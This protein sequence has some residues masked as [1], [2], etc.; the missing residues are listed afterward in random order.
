MAT[1]SFK[2]QADYEKVVKLKEEIAKLETQ[3]KSFGRNTPVN[4]IHAVE[5]K[6]S[7]SKSQFNALATEAAKAGAVMNNDFKN[8]IAESTA[9]VDDL[10]MKII[11]Q[12]STIRT[13]EADVRRLSEAYKEMSKKGSSSNT[14]AAKAELD[15]AKKSLAEE[16]EALFALNQ[17]KSKASLATKKL[18]AEYSAFK[19]EAKQAKDATE[20]FKETAKEASSV[21][22][23]L[24]NT[25][26]GAAASMGALFTIQKAKEFAVEIASVRGQFQQLEMSFETMLQ[27]KSKADALMAQVVDTAAKTPFDLQGVASGAKQL[28]AYGVASEKVNETLIRLGDIASG[29]NIPLGDLVYLYG[30]TMAQGR[31]FTMD[32]RQFQGRGIPM[33]EELA[34]VMGV[35]KQK[36]SELVTAGKVGF[37]EMEQAIKNMTSEGGRF[38]N[39]MEKQSK[40]ITGQYSNLK[41]SISQMFN[42][43]GKSSEGAISGAI[44]L[45]SNLVENYKEVGEAIGKVVLIV[46]SYKAA[47]MTLNAV[48]NAANGVEKQMIEAL[49]A[50]T[51]KK[52]EVDAKE[53]AI[54][55]QKVAANET[56]IESLRRKLALKVEEYQ[57]NLLTAQNEEASAKEKVDKV[58]ELLGASEEK[59]KALREEAIAANLSGDAE[60]FATIQ[61]NLLTAANERDALASELDAAAKAHLAATTN[62]ETAASALN[63]LQTN[64]ETSAINQQ[65]TA[66]LLL[67]AAKQ[68][69]MAIGRGIGSVLANPYVLAAAAVA[70]L[71]ASVIGLI[72]ALNVEDEAQ[73]NVTEA[74][75]KHNEALDENK[76]KGE[77]LISVIK[78][79][80]KTN[81]EKARAIT[82][83]RA[84]YPKLFQDM[85][86][87][88]IL[89]MKQADANRKLAEETERLK[90][91]ELRLSLQRKREALAKQEGTQTVYGANGATYTVDTSN[92]VQARRLREEIRLLE[93]ELSNYEELKKK[94]EFNALPKEAKIVSL[95]EQIASLDAENKELDRQLQELAAKKWTIEELG[96]LDFDW[97][98]DSSAEAILAK[99]E[100][101]RKK[102][103]E[104]TK[105]RK[106]LE[107]EEPSPE[108]TA[109]Q[110]QARYNRKKARD[111]ANDDMIKAERD[112]GYKLTEAK[113]KAMDD[114]LVKELAQLEFNKKKEE[115]AREQ[116]QKDLLKQMQDNERQKWLA[117]DPDRKEYDFVPT[118][119]EN[120]PE[121]LAFV[122]QYKK[123]GEDA[124][125]AYNKAVEDTQT[126]WAFANRQMAIDAM[127]E[128]E[129]KERAQR[130]LDNEKE[131]FQLE[132]K[133]EA[134]L[135]AAEAAHIYA[136]EA[137]KAADPNYQIQ[138]FDKE[139]TSADY[140]A[141]VDNT[142]KKQY[143]ILADEYMSYIDKKSAIDASYEADKAE[144]EE[145]YLKTGDEKYK[146]SL[147]ERTKAY[148]KAQNSLEGE[149][150]TA[151]YRLIFGDPSKMTSATIEKALEAAR[152]KMAEL[153]KEAD[154]ETFQALSEA[155]DRLEDARDNNPFEGWGTSIM[156]V[157]R[158]LH[159]IRNLKKDIERYKASGDTK[160]QEAAE[161]QL[162]KSKK[163]LNKALIGTGVATFGDTLTKA[164]ASMKEVAEASGDIELMQQAKALE[165][166]GGFISSVASGFASG[167]PM[168]ALVGGATAL[169]DMLISSITETKV[170][171]AQAKKAFGDYLDE[172]A[173]KARTINEEDY[174][175]IFG[176][177]T[178]DK[179]HDATDAAGKAWE[180]YQAALNKE[181]SNWWHLKDWQHLAKN[182]S[183]M[184]VFEGKSQTNRN[185]KKSKTLAERFPEL[186]NSDDTIKR[187]EAKMILDSYSQYASEEWYKYLQYAYDALVDYEDN[188]KIVDNYLTSLFS[189]VGSEITDAIM[190]GNDALEVLEQ[191]AGEIFKS[192]A[193]EMIMSTLIPQDFIGKYKEM[194]RKTMAT[195]GAED[196]AMVLRDFADELGANIEEASAQWEEL[197]RI[198]EEKGI[199]MFGAEDTTQQASTKGYQTLSE[200]TGNELVGRALAQYESNLRME[201][202]MGEMQKTM[203]MMS[204]DYITVK[205]I[206]EES[207]ALIASSYLEL[208]QIR[209]NTGAIIKPIKN[210]SD[211]IDRWDNK[212]MGL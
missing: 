26:K 50:T 152:K 109:K 32:L 205:N 203:E 127:S 53:L 126:K 114:G 6:L 110:K 154:P 19:E 122:E 107:N 4:E 12:K 123:L 88:E 137:K 195:E 148:V 99:L 198:A 119:T 74:I 120:S 180:Q 49:L 103:A 171:A 62:T 159:T 77:S 59:I 146:R 174:E 84:L 58:K 31:M 199:D 141:I 186:F 69:L 161:A 1:L 160:A 151:D 196:D 57:T 113:I 80:A 34:K 36:V 63:T 91:E 51:E 130:L 76:S 23:S 11:E 68:K 97:G 176:I 208:Q 183:E 170:V 125:K 177:R 182:L 206:A 155:I 72:D 44:G 117:A 138:A 124:T 40:T 121:Y 79:E 8:K 24:K 48:N 108:E 115:D 173:R 18:K 73:K 200:D 16:K 145:A 158:S 38:A 94:A 64:I 202:S 162:E 46:G 104:L 52:N 100:E 92:S 211:K 5:Q 17:E 9:V 89:A 192:I 172:V 37:P 39:L 45:A 28:L 60:G 134:Y 168:G 30:T 15:A 212:I 194:L 2:V 135:A 136:E 150:N 54:T 43:I 47:L 96:N 179:V 21:G 144:L 133:K 75:K 101:N 116:A 82:E 33:A 111:K 164:A 118:I 188:L 142:K 167:G 86:D 55:E 157:A 184:I 81:M 67:K 181:S 93:K 65:T 35:T 191:N 197:K 98:A 175:A 190:Q 178:L 66:T 132:Q 20:E 71:V 61:A 128:G 102:A 166:A 201:A 78:D 140:D 3:L 163:D 106:T 41:D 207:R 85:T 29:L 7:A 27:S 42:E 193:K 131:V 87:A 10:T 169:M 209:E 83:L 56:E 210:L 153:D 129:S 25:L 156:D 149:Y 14:E 95:N 165:K 13:V 189:N 105:E 139:K 204:S 90:E 185:A 147:D 112:L 70:A 187:D 22:S 143:D